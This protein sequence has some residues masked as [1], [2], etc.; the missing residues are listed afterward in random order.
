MN[1]LRK[2]TVGLLSK[3]LGWLLYYSKFAKENDACLVEDF[4]Y[5]FLCAIR[6]HIIEVQSLRAFLSVAAAS[7][8]TACLDQFLDKEFASLEF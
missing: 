2:R 6:H 1:R 5:D 8:W 3:E 7:S 4:E